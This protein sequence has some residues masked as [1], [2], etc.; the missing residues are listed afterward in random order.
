MGKKIQVGYGSDGRKD[1]TKK[2]LY[3]GKRSGRVKMNGGFNYGI[4]VDFTKIDDEKWKAAFPNS[5]VPYWARED[6]DK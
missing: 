6:K 3:G 2:G 4:V 5:Y 1:S